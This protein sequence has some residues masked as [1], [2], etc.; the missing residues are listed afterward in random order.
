MQEPNC[1]NVLEISAQIRLPARGN[2]V[3]FR[4][5]AEEIGKESFSKIN[6][7]ISLVSHW[8]I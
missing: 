6:D 8:E 4:G 3:V 5:V 2:S 7:L 1:L